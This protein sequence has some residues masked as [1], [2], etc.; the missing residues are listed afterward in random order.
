M[1]F[2]IILLIFVCVLIYIIVYISNI[3]LKQGKKI[4]ENISYIL[5]AYT[6]FV[7]VSTAGLTKFLLIDYIELNTKYNELINNQKETEKQENLEFYKQK[8]EYLQKEISDYIYI[9]SN[10]EGSK[11]FYKKEISQKE[12]EIKEK[13]FII[14]TYKIQN[15]SDNIKK[16]ILYKKEVVIKE[17]T[18]YKD[19]VSGI[20]IGISDI[21][22][23]GSIS[24]IINFNEKELEFYDVK[25]GGIW[26]SNYKNKK[27]EIL[28]KE[29]S[30]VN[31]TC[32]ILITEE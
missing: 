16:E 8:V 13:D 23:F 11:E 17:N 31:G 7:S 6:C 14:S 15:K 4:D 10:I 1:I 26:Q 29:I 2:Y 32:T 12:Q 25:V 20:S 22:T 5:I 21:T 27:Y 3:I 19:D 18:A 28:V 9:L 24:G 30:F